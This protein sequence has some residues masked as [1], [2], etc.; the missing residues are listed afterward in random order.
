MG[1]SILLMDAIKIRAPPPNP[2]TEWVKRF[3]CLFVEVIKRAVSYWILKVGFHL[4]P[5]P[6]ACPLLSLIDTLA[7]TLRSSSK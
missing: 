7:N 1:D 6:G 4:I 2:V 5:H 3:S